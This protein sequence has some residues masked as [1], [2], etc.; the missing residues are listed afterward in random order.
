MIL[1]L[2]DKTENRCHFAIFFIFVVEKY[3][4]IIMLRDKIIDSGC[5]G[6][7]LYLD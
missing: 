2:L 5:A 7:K 4:I 3:D 6:I 1:V